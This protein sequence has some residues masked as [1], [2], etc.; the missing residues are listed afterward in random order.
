MNYLLITSMYP[1]KSDLYRNAFIHRRIKSYNEYNPNISVTVYVLSKKKELNFYTFDSVNVI[2]GNKSE[3]LNIIKKRKPKKILIHFLNHR[4]IEVIKRSEFK[5]PIIIWIHGVEALGWY[6]RLFDFNFRSFPRYVIGNIRQ[7]IRLR[8]FINRSKNEDVTYVF[9]SNW[10]KKV[11]ERDT[12]T[13]VEKYEI[14]P[15]I[16]DSNLFNYRVKKANLRKKI[17]LIRSFETKKYANDIAIKAILLLS[18]KP[19]FNELQFTIC[20]KGRHFNSLTNKI[21]D[22]KNIKLYNEFLTQKEI[23]EVHKENGLFLCPTRQDSQGVSMCEAM[24][25][26]LVPITSNNTAIPEFVKD[27]TTGLLTNSPQEIVD[28]I[29][30]LYKNKDEFFRL[31]FNASKA[32]N[33]KCN[34]TNVITRELDLI[35]K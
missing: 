1:K 9:V 15:N 29:D 16:I 8:D 11:M 28:S 4:M 34:S 10:M 5:I 35:L 22:F 27:N 20:G 7:M 24:S 30:Y 23:S 33:E 3:L 18:K 19:Y 31:S 25:S 17:L 26:G 6:R 14:I 2:E 13:K 12:F 32:I 21:K